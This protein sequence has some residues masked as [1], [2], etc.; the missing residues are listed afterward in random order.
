MADVIVGRNPV[1]EALKAGRSLNKI[2]ISRGVDNQPVIAE[3]TQL[4]R[5]RNVPVEY[6]AREA[7]DRLSA[8][9]VHQ[10]VAAVAVPREYLALDDLLEIS[11]KKNEA[12]LY[13]VLDGIE[14]PH[15]L[16][17]IIRTA[18]ASGVHGIVIRSRR[19]AG[20]TEAVSRASAGAV[21]YLPVAMVSNIAQ[22][23]EWLKKKNIWVFGIDARGETDYTRADF[24]IAAAI[25]IGS[26]GQGIS[27][28][29]RKRCDYLV[30]IPMKGMITSLNAS[31]AAGIVMY[32][33]F[34]QRQFK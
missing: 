8:G 14:D 28:L 2:I 1:L 12:P 34:R 11:N 27:D 32:E 10:G 15:N 19:A 29:V 17:A 24:K 23:V 6:A 7:I 20:V 21:E 4:A 31:V 26:E 16:G 5:S 9:S 3:I 33:A 22:S 18:E 30:S 13:C 25:V